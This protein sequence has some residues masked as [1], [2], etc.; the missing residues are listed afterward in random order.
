MLKE[1]PPGMATGLKAIS[2]PLDQVNVR[3]LRLL[4]AEPRLSMSELARRV[5]MSPPA[6]TERVQ[7]MEEAGVIAGYRLELDP[8]ALGLPVAAYVRIRPAPGQLRRV[9]QVAQDAPEVVECH[10]VTGEDCFIVKVHVSALDALEEV[11]DR[12]LAYGQTTSS[13]VQSSPVPLR[14]LPLPEEGAADPGGRGRPHPGQ[15]RQ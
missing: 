12:F 3:I 14:A 15:A 1:S 6:V 4:S 11:L 8:A 10:R 5:K 13:I 2:T 9:A 7:R